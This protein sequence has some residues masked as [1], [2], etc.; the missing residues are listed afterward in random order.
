[1]CCGQVGTADEIKPTHSKARFGSADSYGPCCVLRTPM[2]KQNWEKILG[3]N[4][5]TPEYD[6]KREEFF[7]KLMG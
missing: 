6:K 5:G 1:M 2:H 3:A 7:R 4:Y